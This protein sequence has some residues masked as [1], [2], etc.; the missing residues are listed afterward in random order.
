MAAQRLQS[1]W[2][3]TSER[4]ALDRLLEAV[5]GGQSM[6]LVIR[7]E[8]G[9]G[10]TALLWYAVRQASGFRIT[11]IAGVESEMELAFAGLHQL[12]GP[13]L[14]RLDAL[15]PPQRA[16]LRVTFG[17][18]SGEAP[19][20]FMVAL[21]ALSL[22]S[23]LAEEQ[24]LLC[25]VDDAQWLDRASMQVL[26]FVGRRLL[27]E[28][29]AIVF[30]VREPSDERELAGLPELPL[31]GLEEEDAR[32]LLATVIPGPLDEQVRHRIVAETRGNPLALLELPRGM[33]AA[34]LAG[35]FA[36]PNTGSLPRHIENHYQRRL[37]SLPDATRRLLLL[38][39]AD[40]VGDATLLWRA[41]GTL[42][43]QRDAAEPAATEQLLE[44][45]AEV[46]FRHPLVRS[47][48]YRAAAAPDRRAA[49]SA[50]AAASDA[51]TDPDRR[52]W[53]RAHA[54]IA[55]DED[56]ASELSRSASR[57]QARGGIAAAA[58]F[59]E[60]AVSFTPD[61]TERASRALS[62]ARA[63]AAVGDHAAAESLLAIA[64][65]GPLDRLGR[66]HVQRL[67]AQ[68]AFDLRRGSDA[69]PLLL[70]AAQRLEALDPELARE[71]YLEALLSAI[72]AARLATG[73][74]LS[75]VARAA[76]S[77]LV[78]REP[79]RDAQL[80]LLGLATRFT[81]GYAAAAPT[82]SKALGAYRNEEPRL[83]LSSLSYN[84]VAMELWDDQAWLELASGQAE[85]ARATG[86]LS[87]LPYA[88]D[89]LAEYHIQA[90]DLRVAAG[91]L[92]EREGLEMG[93]KADT[94]P[95][96]PLLLAVW[97]GQASTALEL[98][99]EMHRGAHARGEGCAITVA[100]YAAAIL[101][102]SLGQY[103]LALDAA[104][105]AAS[106]DEIAI[107]SWALYELAE[108]ASRNGSRDVARAAVDQLSERTRASGTNWARGTWA[109]SRALV[110]DGQSA[111]DFHRQ[112]IDW[113]GQCGMRTH[114]A[115]ARLTFGEWLRRANRRVD[116]REQLR[117]AYD[118]LTSIGADR[119]AE[120]ARRELI[121]TGETVRKRREDTRDQ[122]T[123]HEEHIARLAREGRTN[124]EIGAELFI[125]DRT[126]EWH[127][128]K[129]FAKLGISSRMGLH[130][131]L[132]SRSREV[133]SA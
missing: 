119:F 21:A 38:A 59:L 35:G 113:L 108:A 33:S 129:V 91:V 87:L 16:A 111:E 92:T 70:R 90:G 115:R 81:A 76:R 114:L 96:V 131:A 65:V 122:L 112:A 93:L 30:A 3:R 54:A 123:P 50:L 86:T 83:D 75:D 100:E 47:A 128:R 56:V 42:G 57:A 73:I 102:N 72:Y 63:K 80:L 49:H 97:R 66:A 4:E 25:L 94:L 44:I 74:E 61:P 84:I 5:R 53:H 85:L 26:G 7:G 41:A 9:I 116:A 98:I 110:E 107:S 15:P 71:T 117:S 99:E 95:Y 64:E 127:L 82:L 17:L 78:G 124:Q 23:G 121:A 28:S 29:V 1:F 126:V 77:A 130:D 103:E 12:C 58:A 31:A 19:D 109:R 67:R 118:L 60:R 43:I 39:A 132:P 11:Q 62:A 101:Y 20:R 6:V 14:G 46:R 120:R 125:S 34:E 106:T 133:A 69:P 36:L 32:G 10:K 88:L 18:S 52:A 22:L 105:K 51:E 89:Y 8:A 79:L 40:P 37:G 68:M 24:P 13:M 45:G 104:Q 27:A 48:I 55:P 2:G